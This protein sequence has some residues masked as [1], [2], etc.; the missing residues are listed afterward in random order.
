MNR[1]DVSK[2][3][4]RERN[5]AIDMLSYQGAERR[6]REQAFKDLGTKG[7]SYAYEQAEA[8]DFMETSVLTVENKNTAARFQYGYKQ[9][10]LG[11][12]MAI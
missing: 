6:G 9:V 8:V 12:F 10:V 2:L 7:F 1:I 3:S 4:A 11:Y 5:R